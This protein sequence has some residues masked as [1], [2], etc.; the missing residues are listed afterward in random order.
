MGPATR[1]IFFSGYPC[2]AR[3][4]FPGLHGI[5]VSDQSEGKAFLFALRGLAKCS[6]ARCSWFKRSAGFGTQTR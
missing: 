5:V 2:R 4:G 3:A 1:G 6:H